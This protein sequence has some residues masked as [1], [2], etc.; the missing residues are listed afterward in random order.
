MTQFYPTD[1]KYTDDGLPIIH[2]IKNPTVPSPV[3]GAVAVCGQCGLRIMR[4]MGY[5]C[6]HAN[7]PT[8]FGP[9]MCIAK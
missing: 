6:P 7:C 4:V 5:V 1:Q 2:P 9:V 8:G 3:D